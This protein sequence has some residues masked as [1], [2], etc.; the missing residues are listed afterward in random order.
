V[1]GGRKEREEREKRKE[2]K[3]GKKDKRKR[4]PK[5]REKENSKQKK[6]ITPYPPELSHSLLSLD[7]KVRTPSWPPRVW[8]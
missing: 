3:E 4:D 2:R 8:A 6:N 1:T 7:C 5:E